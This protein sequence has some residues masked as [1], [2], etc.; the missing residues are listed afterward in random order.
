MEERPYCTPC[1]IFCRVLVSANK[2]IAA[3]PDSMT[4]IMKNSYRPVIAKPA[5]TGV[6]GSAESGYKALS[7]PAN[8]LAA[9][10]DE[11]HIPINNEANFTG[12][13]LTTI[14]K[15]M[16][17]KHNSPMVCS[18]YKLNSHIMLTLVAGSTP[19]T[20]KAIIQ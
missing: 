13:S 3:S 6:A 16:G 15:P 2:M 10:I 7:V 17:D 19:L 4:K 9:A 18:K 20:P 11:N 1:I 8:L 14:A 5:K 12:D